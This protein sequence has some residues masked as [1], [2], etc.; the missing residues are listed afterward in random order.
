[1]PGINTQVIL[2]GNLFE[3]PKQ[4]TDYHINLMTKDLAQ[5]AELAV[6]FQGQSS[7]RYESSPPTGAWMRSVKTRV[8]AAVGGLKGWEVHDS[9]IVYGPW[10]EGVSRR[11]EATPFKGYA[12]FRKVQQELERKAPRMV[13]PDVRRMTRK[14]EA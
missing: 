12:M 1:M 4:I 14:L 5:Q 10:L 11:N 8:S 3:R 6:K 9:G 7:F 2:S 13:M